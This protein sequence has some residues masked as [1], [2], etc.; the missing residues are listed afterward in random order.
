MLLRG[1]HPFLWVTPAKQA[2]L[3]LWGS[4][5]PEFY[6]GNTLLHPA[7]LS[8]SPMLS[9]IP[10]LPVPQTPEEPFPISVLVMTQALALRTSRSPCSWKR[11]RRLNRL[12]K[13]K[14]F[15]SA[16]WTR[17]RMFC[18]LPRGLARLCFG[19]KKPWACTGSSIL[20]LSW[21]AGFPR[22]RCGCPPGCGASSVP[23]K[24]TSP[25]SHHCCGEVFPAKVLLAI[26]SALWCVSATPPVLLPAGCLI[27]LLE[28]QTLV[29]SAELPPAAG[30]SRCSKV[31][32]WKLFFPLD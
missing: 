19:D 4:S 7:L 20:M 10:S 8:P 30:S 24:H 5:Q 32:S 3:I 2:A 12:Q 22:K 14:F 15:S 31:S 26:N 16:F 18:F 1:K 9:A 23:S 25:P 27:S 11:D 28:C 29:I 13:R 17:P 6:R 21:L